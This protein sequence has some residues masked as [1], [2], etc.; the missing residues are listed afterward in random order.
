MDIDYVVISLRCTACRS[1]ERVLL[2]SANESGDAHCSTCGSTLF[3]A[4]I[5]AGFL[6]VLTN[7]RMPGLLKIGCTNRAVEKRVEELNAATGVPAPFIVEAIYPSMAP[8]DDESRVH[9]WMSEVRVVGKEFFEIEVAEALSIIQSVVGK[10]ALFTRSVQPDYVELKSV[11]R[12][13]CGLCKNLWDSPLEASF[14]ECPRC[15]SAAVVKLGAARGVL[16]QG[17]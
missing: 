2:S 1:T 9:E 15:S 4:C 13:S 8:L 12:W 17:G 11:I 7:S 16:P 5:P 6:Y 3:S 10:N 14:E